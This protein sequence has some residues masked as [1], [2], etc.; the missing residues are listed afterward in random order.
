MLLRA[1]VLDR[2]RE[3]LKAPSPEGQASRVTADFVR[4]MACNVFTIEGERIRTYTVSNNTAAFAQAM[5]GRSG[6]SAA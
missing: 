4:A 3:A 2:F 5:S 1:D 6:Q